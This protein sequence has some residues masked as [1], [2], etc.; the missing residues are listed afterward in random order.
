[1]E[2]IINKEYVES[3]TPQTE[4]KHVGWFWDHLERKFYRWDNSPHRTK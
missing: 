3:K 2:K 4:Q 1:M